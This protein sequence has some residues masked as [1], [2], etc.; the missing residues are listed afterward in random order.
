MPRVRDDVRDLS[1]AD[2]SRLRPLRGLAGDRFVNSLWG[3]EMNLSTHAQN[4]EV[5]SLSDSTVPLS[6]PVN[7]DREKQ[8][9]EQNAASIAGG[10]NLKSLAEIDCSINSDE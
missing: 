3:A 9:V 4:V 2:H 10:G 5:L 7:N 1:A 6:G 8:A